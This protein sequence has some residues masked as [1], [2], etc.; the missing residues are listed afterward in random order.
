VSTDVEVSVRFVRMARQVLADQV[1]GVSLDEALFAGPGARSSLG[2]LK[3]IGGWLWVYWSYAFEA[4]PRHW[5]RTHW[6]R[7]LRETVEL[8]EEYFEEVAAWADAGLEAWEKSLAG[9]PGGEMGQ[10]RRLHWGAQAPL[11]EIVVLAMQHVFYH[12]GEMNLLLSAKRGEAWE[13][14]EEVEENHIDT[15]AFGVRP[16]WMNDDQANAAA[17]ARLAKRG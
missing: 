1:R 3:H 8:S 12:A 5:E 17:A 16:P 4:E 14:G 9:I 15:F 10:L 13:W 11:E 6:P 2:V 7:G